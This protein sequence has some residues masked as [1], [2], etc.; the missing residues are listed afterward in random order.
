MCVC[1]RTRCRRLGCLLCAFIFCLET[2]MVESDSYEVLFMG[3]VLAGLASSMLH[4]VFEPWLITEAK[5]IHASDAWLSDVFG[6]QV[7]GLPLVVCRSCVGAFCVCLRVCLC[8]CGFVS[9]SLSLSLCVCARGRDYA[10]VC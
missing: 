9:L 10:S 5:R 4:S 8:A 7:R 1:A 2:L 6:V 3:R